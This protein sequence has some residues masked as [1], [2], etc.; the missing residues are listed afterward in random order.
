MVVYI[1]DFHVLQQQS[2]TLYIP[3]L[4]KHTIYTLKQLGPAP[5]YKLTPVPGTICILS[6]PHPLSVYVNKTTH[7]SSVHREFDVCFLRT[8]PA[9]LVQVLYKTAKMTPEVIVKIGSGGAAKGSKVVSLLHLY[10]DLVKY[11]PQDYNVVSVVPPFTQVLEALLSSYV[12]D[13]LPHCPGVTVK[14]GHKEGGLDPALLHPRIKVALDRQ[15]TMH[16]PLL[17]HEYV[18]AASV[19]LGAYAS[20][21]LSINYLDQSQ[22]HD[23]LVSLLTR[24]A[25]RFKPLLNSSLAQEF[26]LSPNITD[27]TSLALLAGRL[28]LIHASVNTLMLYV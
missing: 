17:P 15:F 16:K 1:Q 22:R 10:P 4:D 12:S 19:V 9:F 11:R 21:L 2:A 7:P 8:A 3:V 25:A 28:Y 23:L 5:R 27:N 14:Y 13:D 20:A 24:A 26:K 18:K 6:P